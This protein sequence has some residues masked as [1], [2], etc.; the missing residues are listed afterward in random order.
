VF[1]TANDETVVEDE[2]QVVDETAG[3]SLSMSPL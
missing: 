3:E 2:R 1:I